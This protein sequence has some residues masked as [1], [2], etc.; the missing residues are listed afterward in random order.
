MVKFWLRIAGHWDTPALV[1][2]ACALAQTIETHWAKH[3]KEILDNAGYSSVWMQPDCVDQGQLIADLEQHL[4]DQFIQSWQHKLSVTT[5]SLRTYKMIKEQFG[6]E[7][8]FELSPH[9]SV[10]AAQLRTNLE[11]LRIETERYYLPNALPVE[12]RTCWFCEDGSVEDE[13]HFLINCKLY[14]ETTERKDLMCDCRALNPSFE[15][16]TSI[17]KLQFISFSNDNTLSLL[18]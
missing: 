16:L 14:T 11:P 9:I 15:H 6:P 17:D 8:Y 2:E 10:P 12:G 7:K 3:I 18:L 13:F 1:K 4:L 5:G